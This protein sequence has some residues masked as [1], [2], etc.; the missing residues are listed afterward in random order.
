MAFYRKKPVAVEAIQYTEET[1]DQIIE[2]VPDLVHVGTS[3][4]GEQYELENMRVF[5][6]EGEMMIRPG[7]WVIKGVHGEFYP[8]KPEIFDA[9]YESEDKV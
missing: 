2:W 7:D 8:C 4:E 9:T 5:T 6:L 3:E 1:R